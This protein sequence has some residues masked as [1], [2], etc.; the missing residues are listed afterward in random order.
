MPAQERSLQTDGPDLGGDQSFHQ[1]RHR[2]AM[3]TN[4]SPKGSHPRAEVQLSQWDE[5]AWDQDDQE[6]AACRHRAHQLLSRSNLGFHRL[7][8]RVSGLRRRLAGERWVRRL[9]AAAA[10]LAAI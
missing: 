2:E 10:A 5:S 9:A 1:R 8:D 7:R 4:T 3:A 6:D